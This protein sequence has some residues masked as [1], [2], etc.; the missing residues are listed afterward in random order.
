M[1][2]GTINVVRIA[3]ASW[4]I[5][6]EERIPLSFEVNVLRIFHVQSRMSTLVNGR[7]S[8]LFQVTSDNHTVWIAIA[9]VL[10]LCCTLVTLLIRVFIRFM[11]SPPFGSDDFVMLVATASIISSI[12]VA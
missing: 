10:G 1:H 3:V 9:T 8:P 4:Q 12:D 7:Y 11:I 6:V 2:G 5:S